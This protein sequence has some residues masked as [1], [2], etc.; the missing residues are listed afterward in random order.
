MTI[1]E[2]KHLR[3]GDRVLIEAVIDS[4]CGD[5]FQ[6][7][8]VLIAIKGY[9]D[10]VDVAPEDIREKLPTPRRKFRKGDIVSRNGHLYYVADDE[11]NN[12]KVLLDCWDDGIMHTRADLLT[13]ERAVENRENRSAADVS[14][15]TI[16]AAADGSGVTRKGGEV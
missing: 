2:A 8:R 16:S 4:L 7:N 11:L 1:E 6:E 5:I 10:S 15:V 14:G 3:P 13:L 9:A 12:G